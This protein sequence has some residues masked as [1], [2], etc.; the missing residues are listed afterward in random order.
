MNLTW[1]RKIIEQLTQEGVE[2]FVFCAGARNSP[3]VVTLDRA[4]GIHA[5]SFFEERCASFFALGLARARGRPVAVITTSGT[6]VAE[7]LPATIEAF[8][9]GV[10]LILVTADRPRRLR[11]TGAPQAIDQ[12][13]LFGKFVAAEFDLENGEMPSLKDWQKRSP[14]HI[15]VCFDEPLIDEKHEPFSLA[16]SKVESFAGVSRTPRTEPSEQ[17]AERVRKF[18]E[19]VSAGQLLV[20]VGTLETKDERESVT[21][22]LRELGAPA[23]FEATSGL[24]EDA[25]LAEI[26]LRSGDKILPLALSRFGVRKVLRIGG[27]PTA[28]VWRDLE[29][30]KVAVETLSVSPLPFAGLSRGEFVCAGV[31]ETFSQLTIR[32]TGSAETL[33]THDRKLAEKLESLLRCEPTSEAGLVR[34]LSERIPRSALMYVGN[35]LPIREWDLAASYSGPA[36]VVE[37]N[38]GVN[39][40]D[41]QISTFL[42][43]AR[44]HSA[45]WC[46][47]GDLTA[48]YDMAAP[49]AL[50]QRKVGSVC[51]AIINNGGGKI[52]NRIFNNELFENRHTF[53]FSNW[54]AQWRWSYEKWT[55][56]PETLSVWSKP[57]VIEIVPDAHATKRFWDQYDALF[58]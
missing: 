4:S 30:P 39:G 10:P 37:A 49:W 23:Y 9:T 32:L 34:T 18:L 46:L 27:V 29:D 14:I 41:G 3:I 16:V 8:H 57:V 15:N 51:V 21:K 11:G 1:S 54:A 53:D 24:R 56:I 2:D 22:F 47:V 40:I 33:L 17:A 55:E 43:L 25:S 28:R 42:G 35:S 7:L 48:L 19:G 6:A 5:Y 36:R 50:S 13:G 45:N 26:A 44:E 31:A 12:K 38:R 58:N 20:L 52:F